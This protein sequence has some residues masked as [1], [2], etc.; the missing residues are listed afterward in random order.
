MMS[1]PILVEIL[2]V[3][4]SSFR[5][6]RSLKTMRLPVRVT[7][8]SPTSFSQAARLLNINSGSAGDVI[9]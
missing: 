3:L 7:V 8:E 4:K 9:D 2:Q 6:Q 5:T 1:D